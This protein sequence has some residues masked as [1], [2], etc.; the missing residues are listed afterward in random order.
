MLDG[1]LIPIF[2]QIYSVVLFVA[3][4]LWGLNR[5]LL[6]LTYYLMALTGW[7]AT[8]MFSP[9]IDLVSQQTSLL[10]PGIVTIAA[11]VMAIGYLLAVFGVAKLVEPKSAIAWLM[12]AL[13]I[14]T[15]APSLYMGMD[16]MRRSIASSFYQAVF[17]ELQ[18]GSSSIE[19]LNQL[20][21]GDAGDLSVWPLLNNY[22]VFL[23][24]YDLGID[25]SDVAM[26]YL[27][28]DGCDAVRSSGC[29][30]AGSLP[31][32][33]YATGEFFDLGRSST[34][35]PVMTAE[36][37]QASIEKG[38][39]GIWVLFSGFSLSIFA[40]LEAVINFCLT[41]AFALGFISLLIALPFAFFKKT[42]SIP[43]A[44]LDVILA[45]FI[46]SIITALLLALVMSFVVIAAGTGNGFLLFGVSFIG[47]VLLV[48]LLVGAVS[49]IL[50]AGNSLVGAFSNVTAGNLGTAGKFTDIAGTGLTAASFLGTSG[51]LSQAAGAALGP[52]VAQKAYF[53]AR[54]FGTDSIM[55]KIAEDVA[56]GGFAASLGP[57]GAL[58]LAQT[59]ANYGTGMGIAPL[60]RRMGAMGTKIEV[61]QEAEPE[62]EVDGI[63]RR[64]AFRA[65]RRVSN[66]AE[67]DVSRGEANADL[68]P[69]EG[70]WL[71]YMAKL[72]RME[73]DE[74]P[75]MGTGIQMHSSSA[76]S[77]EDI[78]KIDN[79]DDDDLAA[80][81]QKIGSGIDGGLAANDAQ[82]LGT[83]RQLALA[84]TL[85]PAQARRPVGA[86]W[87]IDSE[88]QNAWVDW[89]GR[90]EGMPPVPY[91]E[92]MNFDRSSKLN[93]DASP[94]YLRD[95]DG[96][97]RLNIQDYAAVKT[98]PM[99][100]GAAARG[101][102]YRLNSDEVGRHLLESSEREPEGKISD[103]SFYTGKAAEPVS[104]VSGVG[105][106]TSEKLASI[107]IQSV[108]DLATAEPV[109]LM[110]LQ[111]FS[112]PRSERLIANAQDYAGFSPAALSS[113]SEF[114]AA[115][116]E[117][118]DGEQARLV[119]DLSTALQRALT[120][121]NGE[122]LRP[123]QAQTIAQTAGLPDDKGS[124]NFVAMAS[125]FKLQP[126][127]ASAVLGDVANLGKIGPQLRQ[128]LQASL[129]GISLPNGS[130]VDSQKAVLGLERATALML[131]AAEAAAANAS[132]QTALPDLPPV[133]TMPD[134]LQ[135]ER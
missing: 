79:S 90:A 84:T 11:L 39:A 74:A 41:I 126:E 22:G 118:N 76:L 125:A 102:D 94:M 110:Q 61:D 56:S 99:N 63:M 45:L 69:K 59:D 18:S 73:M 60:I 49:G 88:G 116:D 38:M 30:I 40:V 43:R 108:G 32:Q 13:F 109:T 98:L 48:V 100:N 17:Q 92:V 71:R 62:S 97:E 14:F 58:G 134:N 77:S 75:A 123:A 35:Y 82:G 121:A 46:Q 24:S 115:V 85:S 106:V 16:E 96:T 89:A 122:F 103:S 50:Q 68:L 111:G 55:G 119:T 132:G 6:L 64:S 81:A 131:R 66:N 86:A 5:A 91:G 37:R 8:Q 25:G 4:V 67:A 29:M 120:Q 51:S 101:P 113:A 65:A 80:L 10:L 83:L 21:A 135:G 107:G 20:A 19:G 95:E 57:V 53:A 23:P 127:L 36:E 7:L 33:W 124:S 26:A 72:D 114:A 117:H 15:Y 28:A 54:T 47:I 130:A 1:L 104:A 78:Q 133:T 93:P 31:L 2:Q 44:A 129:E 52:G 27:H 34:F 42:E 87:G 128:S 112:H 3:V 9:V 105:G 12:V 70:Q